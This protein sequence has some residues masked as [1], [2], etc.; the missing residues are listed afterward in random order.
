MV[1]DA[2]YLFCPADE[3][4]CNKQNGGYALSNSELDEDEHNLEYDFKFGTFSMTGDDVC[5]YQITYKKSSWGNITLYFDQLEFSQAKLF[6]W[7]KSA[8]NGSSDEP[9]EYLGLLEEGQNY[10]VEPDLYDSFYVLLKAFDNAP[11]YSDVGG[12]FYVSADTIE[13]DPPVWGIWLS[14]TI[15]LGV[16]CC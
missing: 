13:Q 11:Y 7:P 16:L 14:I 6:K 10:T 1:T 5:W 3:P 12:K 8:I 9:I 2:P 4:T 15:I